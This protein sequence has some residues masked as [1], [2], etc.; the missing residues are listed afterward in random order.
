MDIHKVIGKLPRPRKGF[1]LYKHKY[2]GPYNPLN[3]QLDRND[4]PVHGQEPYNSV[5]A[6]SMQHDICYRDNNSK[7][8]KEKCDDEMLKEL[9]ILK[10]K[11]AREK[12]DKKLTK[13]IIGVKRYL[14]MSIT[15]KN[16]LADELHKPIKKKFKKR[17]VY[18]KEA[19]SIWAADLVDMTA[20]SKYNKGYKYILMVIDI[21]SK[22]GWAFPLK[23]KK[24]DEVAKTFSKL[25]QNEVPP[26]RLWVDKGSEFFNKAMKLVNK[27][28]NIKMYTTE[29]EEKSSVVERWNRTIKR[30]MYK[31][32]TANNTNVYIDK[33][34]DIVDK[35]NH[36][37]HH[38]IK[39][40]PA[41][42]RES[43]N[44]QHVYHAL[45]GN[46]DER[47]I[48]KVKALENAK[49]KVGDR[50][51]IVRKKKTF[52]KGF[53]PNWSE[54]IFTIDKVK[55][56]NPVTYSI[57]DFDGEEIK[58]SFYEQELQKTKQEIFRIEKVVKKRRR[59]GVQE[60]FVKWLG[61]NK[62]SWIPISDLEQ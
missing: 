24:G 40:T 60:V 58:G 27:K 26:K 22:Y 14:G 30:I 50:V 1:M 9:D 33:L 17:K 7:K 35:Y 55:D 45:N 43:S 42:A 32:F 4:Q 49:F 8:G 2:T 15:W 53:T 25:W 18:V 16:E 56:T 28:K 13:S 59:N 61:Y 20:F 37:Y 11:D 21:F 62:H 36:T 3:E 39:C 31:Y 51:R 44:H 47:Y 34:Q 41:S 52:E 48:A 57:I 46:E 29:N 6:I 10:P 23:T 19:N 54:E 5:D 38:S 12:I